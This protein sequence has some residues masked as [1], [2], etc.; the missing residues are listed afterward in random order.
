[1]TVL[2][3]Q[4]LAALQHTAPSMTANLM[5]LTED[6]STCRH[7]QLHHTILPLSEMP[8]IMNRL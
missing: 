8:R 7:V 1:M 6:S 3:P 2:V 4:V 5:A